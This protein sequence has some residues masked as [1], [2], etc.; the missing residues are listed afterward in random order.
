MA[1][2]AVP[3]RKDFMAALKKDSSV[4]EER[5]CEDMRTSLVALKSNIDEIDRFYTEKGQ[6]SDDTV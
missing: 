6:H 4:S 3:Y 1:V 5:V 2:H